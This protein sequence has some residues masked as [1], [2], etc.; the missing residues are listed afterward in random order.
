MKNYLI[1]SWITCRYRIFSAI[2]PGTIVH[3]CMLSR[4][5]HVRLCAT[6][7]TV[8]CQAPLSMGFLRQEYWSS[9]PYPPPG[10]L[11]DPGVENMSLISPALAGRFFTTSA[12]WEAQV[13][14]QIIANTDLFRSSKVRLY[15]EHHLFGTIQYVTFAD[16]LLLLTTVI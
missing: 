7:W 14:L 13:I 8:A 1:S 3:A 16:W 2:L 4:F 5:N 15:A 12:A 10:D 9:L 6:L 11:P